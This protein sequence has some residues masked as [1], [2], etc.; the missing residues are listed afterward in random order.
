MLSY[1]IFDSSI[2]EK[3]HTSSIHPKKI[4]KHFNECEKKILEQ[5]DN[6]KLTL[7]VQQMKETICTCH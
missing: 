1:S 3:D 5:H 6:K 7:F 2:Q 4:R